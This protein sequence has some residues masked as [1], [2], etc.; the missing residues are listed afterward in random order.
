MRCK[1]S[2]FVVSVA[3]EVD[4]AAAPCFQLPY[5]HAA[6]SG[7]EVDVIARDTALKVYQSDG[8]IGI[9]LLQ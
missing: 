8:F 5:A 1:T 2:S 4:I 3:R 6:A 7:E 9:A